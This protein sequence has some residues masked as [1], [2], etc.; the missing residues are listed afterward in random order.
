MEL[1]SERNS[2]RANTSNSIGIGVGGGLL[3]ASLAVLATSAISLPLMILIGAGATVLGVGATSGH[4]L[5]ARANDQ[6]HHAKLLRNMIEE[7]DV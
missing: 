2:I 4:I 5:S 1:I 6:K 3:T 7:I